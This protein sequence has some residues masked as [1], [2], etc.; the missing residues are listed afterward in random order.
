MAENGK[1]LTRTLSDSSR[2][3]TSSLGSH[4]DT[5]SSRISSPEQD[6]HA[7]AD[8]G[9]PA[10]QAWT[11]PR[12]GSAPPDRRSMMP[13]IT[14]ESMSTVRPVDSVASSTTAEVAADPSVPTPEARQD[15][16]QTD[17]QIDKLLLDGLVVA[18]DRLLL[19]RA[20]LEMEK[21]FNDP[22]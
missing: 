21:L 22:A 14:C 10:A 6:L 18:K 15:R 20:D 2:K 7:A 1:A 4:T 11:G 5:Q 19:L 12:S 13:T 8:A 16:K 17:P 3:R 9:S